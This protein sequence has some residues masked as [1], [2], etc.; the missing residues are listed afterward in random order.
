MSDADITT[1]VTF[2]GE[3]THKEFVEFSAEDTVGDKLALFA[4]LARHVEGW[5]CLRKK[6]S[7]KTSSES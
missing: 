1:R 5:G 7:L 3:F 2:L 6:I 4:D